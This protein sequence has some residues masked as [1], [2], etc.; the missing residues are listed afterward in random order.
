[1]K[2]HDCPWPTVTRNGKLSYGLTATLKTAGD[3]SL[4]AF[5]TRRRPSVK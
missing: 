5:A 4:K 2:V 1:M 3:D